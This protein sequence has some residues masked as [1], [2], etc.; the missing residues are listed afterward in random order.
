[1]TKKREKKQSPNERLKCLR[2]Q[3][4]TTARIRDL[5]VGILSQVNIILSVQEGDIKK[6]EKRACPKC[7]V[8]HSPYG[9]KKHR[10]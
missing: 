9:T 3:Y 1:M 4:D 6:L 7:G 8:I 2:E 10:P 5:I